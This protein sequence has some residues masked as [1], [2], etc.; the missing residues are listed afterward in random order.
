[1]AP[2]VVLVHG[3]GGS[4]ARTWQEPGW[5]ALLND[6]GR[7]VIGVDLLGH[8]SAPKPH[9]V[10]AYA[11]LTAEVLAAVE[12][13][14]QVDAVGFSLGAMTLL[15]VAATHPGL[16]RRLAL[17]GIGASAL[18]STRSSAPI[19][20]ALR[21]E[22]TDDVRAQLFVQYA[23]Q[24][25]NDRVA[26]AACMEALRPRFDPAKLAAVEAKVLVVLGTADD[27]GPGE[28]LVEALADAQL[29]SLPNVDHFA[30]TESFR[31]IDAVL[32]FL[33]AEPGA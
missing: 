17:C 3:W 26:L 27:A 20:A 9:D 25:G 2:P 11:D 19:V 32:R 10:A 15:Q 14:D 24:P 12:G 21:G 4:F 1:M 28:P 30:T 22:P 5:E 13:F 33:T 23:E 18:D 8:G 7:Q 6:E 16:I 29:V 31:C